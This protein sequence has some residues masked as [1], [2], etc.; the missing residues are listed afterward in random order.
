AAYARSKGCEALVVDP[1]LAGAASAAAA[2]LFQEAWA[3]KKGQQ[4]YHRGLPL[5]E[6]LYGI[7]S[8]RLTYDDGSQEAFHCV[9]P[10]LILEPMPIRKMVTAVGDGWL[11]AG[12]AR[13]QGWLYKIGR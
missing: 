11:E 4:H 12:G 7:K 9:P 13:Y 10:S 8:V 1:G 3:G 2:G 5:L 6:K